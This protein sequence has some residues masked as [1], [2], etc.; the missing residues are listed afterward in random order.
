VI[1]L[2]DVNPTRRTPV[3]TIALIV[4]FFLRE[5]PLRTGHEPAGD[6]TLEP[7]QEER[8]LTMVGH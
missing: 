5:I 2:R 4:A 1:P 8:P 3:V 7:E 6:G